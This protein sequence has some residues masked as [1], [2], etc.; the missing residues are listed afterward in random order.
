MA[1][2]AP[3]PHWVRLFL[4]L[5][6]LTISRSAGSDVAEEAIL[7]PAGVMRYF[8]NDVEVHKVTTED[9]YILEVDRILPRST[10]GATITRTPMLLVH[11]LLADAGSWVKNLPSQSAGFLL[12]DS[13]YDV[14][15]V[16]TRGVPQ[17]NY[18]V[19][20]TTNDAAFWNWSFDEIGRYDLPAVVD[21][22]LDLTGFSKLGLLAISQGATDVLVF[23]SMLP[24]YN[25]KVYRA[26]NFVRFDYGIL[27]NLVKYGQV[28][29]PAYPLEQIRVPVAIYQGQGDK[30]AVPQDVDDLSERLKH[31]L[32][33]KYMVPDP[34]FGHLDFLMGFNATDI[35]HSHMIDLISHYTAVA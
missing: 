19:T 9:G 32:V 17:S 28:K 15:L 13:G 10:G 8:G 24:E 7:D 23:L 25:R 16:N 33:L 12:A 6:S 31:V 30:F 35:L 20:L 18:H 1:V 3:A 22:I 2:L 34:D 4:M 14:W 29:P 27:K 11:G 26:R 5:A 21:Y